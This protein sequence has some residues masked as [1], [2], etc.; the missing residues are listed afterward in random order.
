[1]SDIAQF[2][3]WVGKAEETSD[4][5]DLSTCRRMEATLDRNAALM[6]NDA[7]PSLWHWLYFHQITKISETGRDGHAKLGQFLPP[8]T[9][10]RRMWAGG[11]F[12]FLIDLPIGCVATR[13]STIK[14]VEKK[15]GRSG[16]LC[17]VTVLHE[18]FCGGNVCLREE[19]DL[20]YRE[21]EKTG[22]SITLA[23]LAEGCPDILQTIVPSPELLF[24]YSALTFNSHKI[25]YD[26]DYCREVESYPG[27]IFHGPLTATLLVQLALEN[28]EGRKLRAFEFRAISP[29]FDTAAFEL[30]GWLRDEHISLQ[31]VNLEGR[32]AM[33]ATA[34][35]AR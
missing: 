21:D 33:T 8:I 19:H 13:K 10:P 24:R 6:I 16:E 7:L 14:S 3:K 20:V 2:Q 34:E 22:D 32:L 1:M 5:I 25:H 29:L 28:S 15:S 18:I 31:A 26:R 9:L 23:P 30:R 12:E 11:R 35:F 17:F 27:L 4:T